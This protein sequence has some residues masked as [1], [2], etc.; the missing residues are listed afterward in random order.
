[1][2]GGGH[3][4][5]EY[6]VVTSFVGANAGYC[7]T[8]WTSLDPLEYY[9]QPLQSPPPLPPS[10]IHHEQVVPHPGGYDSVTYESTQGGPNGQ[11]A[12]EAEFSD[13]TNASVPPPVPTPAGHEP[14]SGRPMKCEP[15]SQA[16]S[17][18]EFLNYTNAD[19]LPPAPN[20]HEPIADRPMKCEPIRQAARDPI[21]SGQP[22]LVVPPVPVEVREE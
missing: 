5:G 1:V 19:V 11:T 20:G 2:I 4:N 8:N 9:G 6:P 12:S 22:D 21:W 13:F 15:I 7:E 18:P 16:N 10:P 14:L 3:P 17:D